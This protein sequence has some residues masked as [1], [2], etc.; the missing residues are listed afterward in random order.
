MNIQAMLAR[1]GIVL[2]GDQTNFPGALYAGNKRVLTESDSDAEPLAQ[3][4][5]EAKD[6]KTVE[7]N[8]T[9]NALITQLQDAGV[10]PAPSVEVTKEEA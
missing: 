4:S 8:K 7:T 10:I 6:V 2:K 3:L 5:T 1:F 9:V